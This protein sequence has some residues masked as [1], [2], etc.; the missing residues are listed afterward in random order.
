MNAF[1][2]QVES[3]VSVRNRIYYK[4]YLITLGIIRR[5]INTEFPD[6]NASGTK[7]LE[8]ATI[9]MC[10]RDYYRSVWPALRQFLSVLSGSMIR[11]R[12]RNTL[13]VDAVE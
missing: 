6:R 1:G 12:L 3:R 7:A 4:D 11:N 10:L 9:I 5:E 2:R 13:K 8:E